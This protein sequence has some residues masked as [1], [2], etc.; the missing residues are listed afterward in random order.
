MSL[1]RMLFSKYKHLV[2]TAFGHDTYFSIAGKLKAGGVSYRT[3]MDRDSSS[4]GIIGS[5]DNTQYDIY[6]KKEDKHKAQQAIHTN[7]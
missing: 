2:Y 3:E 1:F 4:Q 6:V 7:R 5:K